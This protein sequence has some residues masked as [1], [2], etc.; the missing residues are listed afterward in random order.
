M[1]ENSG[2]FKTVIKYI[3]LE[4][5]YRASNDDGIEYFSDCLITAWIPKELGGRSC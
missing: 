2:I 3:L 4:I 5:I 1:E